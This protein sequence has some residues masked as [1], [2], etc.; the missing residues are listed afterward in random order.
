MRGVT[1][2]LRGMSYATRVKLGALALLG[3]T[4]LLTNLSYLR[5]SRWGTPSSPSPSKFAAY[6]RRFDELRKALPGRGV[7][8]Y[9]SDETDEF[10]K[11]ENYYL[12][13]YV[14]APLVVVRGADRPWVV[15]NFG[16][17][18]QSAA[19]AGARLTPVK[20]FGDGV[21]LFGQE[22]Q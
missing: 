9:V 18:G 4:A 1:T 15:G 16:H 21:V 5:E 19:A 12:T 17:G 11:T 8:G 6:E 14:L 20:D 2:Q 3:L 7:V 22:K 13:Q 10:E